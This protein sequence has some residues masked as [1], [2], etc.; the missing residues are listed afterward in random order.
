MSDLWDE[1]ASK[2]YTSPPHQPAIQIILLFLWI[3]GLGLSCTQVRQAYNIPQLA[4]RV[5]IQQEV[6]LQWLHHAGGNRNDDVT[7][8]TYSMVGYHSNYCSRV[9]LSFAGW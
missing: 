6:W 2:H 4:G 9:P 1:S 8:I 5:C 7:D 3:N